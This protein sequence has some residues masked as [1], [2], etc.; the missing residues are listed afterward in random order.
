MGF[1]SFSQLATRLCCR[2]ILQRRNGTR[3]DG[4]RPPIS[5]V[6]LHYRTLAE[7]GCLKHGQEPDFW[8]AHF[9]SLMQQGLLNICLTEESCQD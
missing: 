8:N 2:S 9:T 3:K 1:N 5:Y 7:H 6:F 4:C